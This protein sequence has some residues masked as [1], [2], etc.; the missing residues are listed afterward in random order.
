MDSKGT[1]VRDPSAALKSTSCQVCDTLRGG[2]EWQ[3]TGVV[4]NVK[5]GWCAFGPMATWQLSKTKGSVDSLVGG[6]QESAV[7]FLE[8]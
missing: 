2:G 4:G 1:L 8:G 6:C 5:V 3:H 7:F